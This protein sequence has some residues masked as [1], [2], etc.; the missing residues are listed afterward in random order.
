[1]LLMTLTGDYFGAQ[2]ANDD[3]VAFNR[4]QA[5]HTALQVDSRTEVA[6][7]VVTGGGIALNGGGARVEHNQALTVDGVQGSFD[8]YVAD[9]TVHGVSLEVTS[10]YALERNVVLGGG[11]HVTGS[12]TLVWGNRVIGAGIVVESPT[13]EEAPGLAA[14]GN[15][16]LGNTVGHAAGDGIFVAGAGC[17][18][19][20]GTCR[21]AAVDTLVRHNTTRHNDDDGIDVEASSTTIARNI[22]R[23]NGDLGIEAVP[24][25]DDGGGN[26]AL[27]NGN[28]ARCTGVVCAG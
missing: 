12:H 15:V 13:L 28:P 27:G 14:T 22:T 3:L 19:G 11:I 17:T 10:G 9:N 16:L 7:N 18:G 2:V 1:V 8:A 5:E 6:Y 20:P 21:P 4:V 25:V 26:R 24:G 23:Y